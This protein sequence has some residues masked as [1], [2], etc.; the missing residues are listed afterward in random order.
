MARMSTPEEIRK[1][2]LDM[3]RIYHDLS[4]DRFAARYNKRYKVPVDAIKRVLQE[5]A[6][7]NVNRSNGISRAKGN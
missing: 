2:I 5:E 6:G 3:R 4:D 7:N 1:S